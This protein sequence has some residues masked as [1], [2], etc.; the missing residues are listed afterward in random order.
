MQ[1]IR[2]VLFWIHLISGIL[3]GV[4]ILT[5]ATTGSLIAFE[6]QLTQ[7]AERQI[8]TVQTPANNAPRLGIDAILQKVKD[9]KPKAKPSGVTLQS[10]ANAAATISLGREGVLFVDPYTGNILGEGSKIRNFFR[11]CTDVHRWLA[12]EGETRP[13][14]KGITGAANVCFFIL[15][16]TGIYIWFPKKFTKQYLNPILFFNFKVKGRARNFNWHNVTGIWIV[17][18][19]LITT[20]TGMIMSYQWANNLLYTLTGNTPP[21]PPAENQPQK[22]NGREGKQ[23]PDSGDKQS[24]KQ[25]NNEVKSKEQNRSAEESNKPENKSEDKL[26]AQPILTAENRENKDNKEGKDKEMS[27]SYDPLWAIAEQ[28]MPA[29]KTISLRMP[30]KPGGPVSF[31]M[32]DGKSWNPTVRSQLTIDPVS[33]AVVKWEPYDQLN[34][35]RKLRLFVKP[36]HTG[37]WFGLP[38]QILNFIVALGIILL[39]WTGFALALKRFSLWRKSR[40]KA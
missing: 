30:N 23:R 34:S 16:L 3:A 28:Q 40:V 33:A 1:K 2:K 24:D 25:V 32:E 29:W 7:F 22:N 21:A 13:I 38:T 17:T 26:P 10:D 19:L 4:V 37:E 6:P 5:M 18:M 27:I 15:A 11:F 35:G 12:S 39:V 20:T 8:R 14:G 36:L 31:T 9:A